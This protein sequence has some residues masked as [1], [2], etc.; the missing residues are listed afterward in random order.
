MIVPNDV[1]PVRVG[2]REERRHWGV[3]RRTAVLR[4][5]GVVIVLASAVNWAQAVVIE[6]VPVENP[7]NA[8]DSHG[9]GYG[10]VAFR[11]NIGK[12][13]VTNAQYC[14]FL[15]AVARGFDVYSLYSG[16]PKAGSFKT[17]PRA[18]TATRCTRAT[19]IS[20][21]CTSLGTTLCDSATG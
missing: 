12:Y 8:A 10:D 20:R 16:L 13:E 2:T 14:E 18:T 15:N 9:S 21:W 7:G 1:V 3:F 4:G 6:T 5:L 17:V 11:Y 19:R